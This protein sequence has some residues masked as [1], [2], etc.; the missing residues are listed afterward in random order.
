MG[1]GLVLGGTLVSPVP[2]PSCHSGHRVL[3]QPGELAQRMLQF[4]AKELDDVRPS[5]T[6]SGFQW[7]DGGGYPGRCRG[8]SSLVFHGRVQPVKERHSTQ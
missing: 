5:F 6:L 2:W 7:G 3:H 1:S 4:K 8:H